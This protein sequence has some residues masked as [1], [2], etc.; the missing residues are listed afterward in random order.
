MASGSMTTSGSAIFFDGVTG[1]R[2]TVKVELGA[3]ALEV[4]GPPGEAL[5]EWP[6]GELAA[7]AAPDG[8]LR[9][10]R[11][12]SPVLARLEIHDHVLAA[13]FTAHAGRI[14]Q[15]GAVEPR[16]RV[17]V[18]GWSLAAVTSA[19]LVALF[20]VPAIVERVT[21]IV[22]VRVEQRL[23]VSV[24]AQVRALL[25]DRS[26]KTAFECG[27]AARSAASRAAFDK[28][29]R[30]LETAAALPVPIHASVVRRSEAN[31]IALPGGRVYVFEGL[32]A[33]ANTP[34][35]LAGVI[36]HEMGHVAHRDGVRAVIQA[37]GLSFLFGMLIGDF[38]GGG[39]AVIA[40]RTV[41][42]SSYSRETEAAADAW[43]ARLMVKLE[44]DPRA[45]GDILMRIAG[46]PGPMAKILLS[47]P[48]ARERAAAIETIA[49]SA[50]V[51]PAA[52]SLSDGPGNAASAGLL[53]AAE[54]AALK[55]ICQAPQT[56]PRT[57]S[58]APSETPQTP[59]A[60][61]QERPGGERRGALPR[62]E[63][64][65]R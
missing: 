38:S 11:A 24:D 61:S 5:A 56:K 31:A 48:E 53:T 30:R 28:L 46:T 42:Q 6:Y 44:R 45:L 21:P 33:K 12:K 7:Y 18:V 13:A 15:F 58:H 19:L 54:W 63:S 22:P 26:K 25:I 59:G 51:K 1:A 43:G 49:R 36:A 29:V 3:T 2:R 50:N 32:V 52:A 16:T 64:S 17:K 9:V 27:D 47:H 10:G 14:K 65:G 23:G 57:I 20:G 62:P 34:D 60:A 4:H 55:K 35:E 41:L 40:M 8:V 39:A 37:G